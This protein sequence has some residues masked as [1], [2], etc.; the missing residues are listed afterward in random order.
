[1]MFFTGTYV[2]MRSIHYA[3]D[4]VN[5]AHNTI[6]GRFIKIDC[7]DVLQLMELYERNGFVLIQKDHDNDL[8]ELAM[9]Y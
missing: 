8:N 1:M 2:E 6:G 5:V 3:I 4:A 7:E 9:F